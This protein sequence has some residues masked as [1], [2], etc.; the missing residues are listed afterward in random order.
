MQPK[1]HETCLNVHGMWKHV[2]F[3]DDFAKEYIRTNQSGASLRYF[4]H[5]QRSGN[6][7]EKNATQSIQVQ[8]CKTHQ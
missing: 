5:R 8:K 6:A 3:Q 1:L 2:Y 4:H 7:K